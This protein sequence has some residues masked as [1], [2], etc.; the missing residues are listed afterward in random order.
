[1]L[2]LQVLNV[3]LH[4]LIYR[5]TPLLGLVEGLEKVYDR[6]LLGHAE[7]RGPEGSDRFEPRIRF[8]TLLDITWEYLAFY[9][10]PL[11]PIDCVMWKFM[12]TPSR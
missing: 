8:L 12:V 1:M 4:F 11:L 2:R 5:W 10:Y 3:L 6:S 7:K 9:F